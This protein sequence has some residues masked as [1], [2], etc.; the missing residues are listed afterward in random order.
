MKALC[1]AVNSMRAFICKKLAPKNEKIEKKI[2]FV[3][4]RKDITTSNKIQTTYNTKK[5]ET[6]LCNKS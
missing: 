6:E 3:I 2:K 5:E 4:S 1:L